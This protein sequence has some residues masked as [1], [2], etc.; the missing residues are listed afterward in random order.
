MCRI[1]PDSRAAVGNGT[2][3]IGSFGGAEA[4][5]VGIN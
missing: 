1:S 5:C 2:M 3:E 4:D